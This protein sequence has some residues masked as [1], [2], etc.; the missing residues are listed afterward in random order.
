MHGIPP[1]AALL[2]L[3]ARTDPTLSTLDIPIA[4]DSEA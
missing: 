4:R 2:Q 1:V 3:L